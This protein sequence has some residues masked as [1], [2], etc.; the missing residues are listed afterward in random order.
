MNTSLP[1]TNTFDLIRSIVFWL[2]AIIFIYS[3]FALIISIIRKNKISSKEFNSNE[4][5]LI[6]SAIG[7]AI[8]E[9][10]FIF[11]FTI[12]RGYYSSCI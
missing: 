6:Y 3:L 9:V 4:K 2:N 10:I 1:S 11:L 8:T 12:F 5:M 7:L